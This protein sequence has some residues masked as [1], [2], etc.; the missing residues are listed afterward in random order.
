MHES[1]RGRRAEGF[2]L[3]VG[4][5][6]AVELGHTL[7]QRVQFAHGGLDLDSMDTTIGGTRKPSSQLRLVRDVLKREP[8]PSC[9]SGNISLFL[10]SR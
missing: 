4:E 5:D 7:A 8:E 6:R 2:Q 3:R 10:R 9:R 1:C